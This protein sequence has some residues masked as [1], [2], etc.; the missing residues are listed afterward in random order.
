MDKGLIYEYTATQQGGAVFV[1]S[2]SDD[3]TFHSC[4]FANNAAE[5]SYGGAVSDNI[6]LRLYYYIYL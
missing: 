1:N 2:A 3:V 5:M 4:N 6:I